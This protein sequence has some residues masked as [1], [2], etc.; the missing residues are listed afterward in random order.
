MQY[1]LPSTLQHVKLSCLID[2]SVEDWTISMLNKPKATWVQIG[3]KQLIQLKSH[4]HVVLKA[5]NITPQPVQVQQE[6]EDYWGLIRGFG[7]SGHKRD[8]N[9]RPPRPNTPETPTK[10]P[11]IAEIVPLSP[12]SGSVISISSNDEPVAIQPIQFRPSNAS[13]ARWPG[14]LSYNQVS[15]DLDNYHKKRTEPPR[16]GWKDAAELVFTG[17][18]ISERHLRR[19]YSVWRYAPQ[20][21]KEE[22]Q[23]HSPQ[24]PWKEFATKYPCQSPVKPEKP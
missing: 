2:T 18:I 15:Q 17:K 21:A 3:P 10:K 19:Q 8:I 11:R 12:D 5:S 13:I 6:L 20:E 1:W 24:R 4:E 22:W 14:K 16:M 9:S 7:I 23:A